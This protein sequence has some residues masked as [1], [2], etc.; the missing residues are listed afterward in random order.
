[1]PAIHGTWAAD[2]GSGGRRKRPAESSFV[3]AVPE[4]VPV[5]ADQLGLQLQGLGFGL[6]RL[7]ANFQSRVVNLLNGPLLSPS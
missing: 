4:L 1:M 2:K 7:P 5:F 6:D 3:S